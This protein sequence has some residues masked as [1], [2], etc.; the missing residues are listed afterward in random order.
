MVSLKS[1]ANSA[2]TFEERKKI[3]IVN[4]IAILELLKSGSFA[5]SQENSGDIVVSSL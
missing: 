1:L 2:T 4:F 3:L 5:V